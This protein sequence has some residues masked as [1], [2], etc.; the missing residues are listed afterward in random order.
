MRPVVGMGLWRQ[1]K[2]SWASCVLDLHSTTQV[3]SWLHATVFIGKL[4]GASVAQSV[5]ASAFHLRFVGSIL[6]TDSCMTL[7][8]KESVNAPAE[9]RGFSPGTP[10]SSHRECW[11]GGLGLSA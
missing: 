4:I 9:I 2:L 5:R 7:V 1:P 8:W 6:A 10:V 11:Q 3:V